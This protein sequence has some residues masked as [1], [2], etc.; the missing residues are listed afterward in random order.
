[1][2][3]Y[4][5]SPTGN[6]TTGNGS[7]SLPWLT[8]QRF[9][10]SSI[11]NDTLI[12]LN[13]T[14]TFANTTGIHYRTIQAQT[15]GSVIFDGNGAVCAWQLQTAPVIT[16]ITF[17]NIKT[18][19]RDSYSYIFGLTSPGATVGSPTFNNC[20][21]HSMLGNNG[22]AK[23]RELVFGIWSPAGGSSFTFNQ[24]LFYNIQG[25][26]SGA[27]IRPLFGSNGVVS[28]NLTG[29]TIAAT[30]TG[31]TALTHLWRTS[32]LI[33]VKNIIAYN[34]SGATLNW[35]DGGT[36]VAT[37]SD[38]YLITGA[39]TGAGVI[40]SNPLFIDP[41]NYDFRLRPTSPCIDTGV[42]L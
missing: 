11:A 15:N 4:Y 19:G 40:T 2:A 31:V 30:V 8:V 34:G 10:T 16:G 5:I 25:H 36:A 27:V 26:T 1:M 13:G 17:R 7:L 9:I 32:G 42:L 24:C 3:T 21:F 39:P 18:P 28:I 38:F 12:C 6:D 20:V 41:V 23:D 29:C 37:Y 22:T 33:T 14:Y 35:K